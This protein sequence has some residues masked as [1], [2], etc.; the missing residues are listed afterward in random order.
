MEE[1]L[2]LEEL[3][4][5]VGDTVIASTNEKGEL[6]AGDGTYELAECHTYA[7]V[8]VYRNKKT[9]KVELMW[10]RTKFTKDIDYTKEAKEE[11]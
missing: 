9:G 10:K 5:N 6:V 4:K 7:I 3:L 8:Y 2:K 1:L 11:I